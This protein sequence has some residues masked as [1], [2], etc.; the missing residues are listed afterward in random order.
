MMMRC[1]LF[2]LIALAAL[3]ACFPA[4]LAEEAAARPVR[5]LAIG[6]SFTHDTFEYLPQLAE[7]AGY[8]M[9]FAVLYIG[10]SQL[11]QHVENAQNDL[12]NYEYGYTL[13]G[14]WIRVNGYTIRQAL[15]MG[16]WDYI[17][18]Q[19]QAVLAGVPETLND[20]NVLMDYVHAFCPEAQIIWNMT[21]AYT[22]AATDFNVREYFANHKAQYEGITDA[23]Q[24][25]ILPNAGISL[26]VPTGTAVENARTSF[27]GKRQHTLFRDNIHLSLYTGRYIAGMTFFSALTGFDVS[28]LSFDDENYKAVAVECVQNALA[29]PF[30]VTPSQCPA[31]DAALYTIPTDTL[32]GMYGG[33]KANGGSKYS[34]LM[35]GNRGWKYDVDIQTDWSYGGA[36]SLRMQETDAVNLL[37]TLNMPGATGISG[38]ARLQFMFSASP[39]AFPADSAMT[40]V[41]RS[42][43]VAEHS[44]TWT[45]P[46][47]QL[48]SE[49]WQ[50]ILLPFGQAEKTGD[51]FAPNR[52]KELQIFCD[53]VQQDAQLQ[54]AQIEIEETP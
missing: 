38:N 29:R 23:T 53:Q 33:W 54:W 28:A 49:G 8:N 11:S 32:Y 16:P 6:N 31:S 26:I 18:L 24:E 17:S 50:T 35:R 48:T 15:E 42:G 39:E 19:Q 51:G 5:V 7:A 45:I 40:I 27:L 34:W 20:V 44:L 10:G 1:F 30:A 43:E 46:A 13:N 21:W 14:K 12:P 9:E 25:M 37:Y 52:F 4:V 2:L 41:L 36:V 47:G 3:T 22:N